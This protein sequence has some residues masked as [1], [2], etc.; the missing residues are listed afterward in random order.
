MTSVTELQLNCAL[1]TGYDNLS[2]DLVI[3]AVESVGYLSDARFFALNSYENRVYQVGIEESSPLI[4]KFY[5]PQRWSDAQILEEHAFTQQL[6]ELE[7]PV[8]AP[9]SDVNGQTLH[10]FGGYRFALFPRMGGQAPESSD[11]DQLHRLGRLLG[12]LHQAGQSHAFLHRPRIDITSFFDEPVRFLLQQ[13]FIPNH[14]RERIETL[15]EKLR[16]GL[17]AQ[18]EG[19]TESTWIRCHGDCHPGNILWNRDSGPWF[20]DFDDCRSAPAVQDLWML[21]CGSRMHQQSQLSELLDGY[22]EFAD[23]DLS[24]LHLIEALRT[25]RIVHYA[26]WLAKRWDD[27]AFP[28]SFPWFNTDHYW[29][30]WLGQLTEQEMALQ[31]EPLQMY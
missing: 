14:W 2:P 13:G 28:R 15:L 29:Q 27:P 1:Q 5:R 22:Q 16:P 19:I 23:F 17:Q 25:L 6:N 4:V 18:L 31:M 20:V 26:G 12:R 7:L 24:Q 10:Y 30:Q 8:I 21:L 11:L 3:S 9:L